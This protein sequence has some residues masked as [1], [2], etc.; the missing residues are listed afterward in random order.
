MSPEQARGHTVD[1]RSDIFALGAILY[2]ILTGRQ[3]F[4]GTTPQ[5]LAAVCN[6]DL[7]PPSSRVD[8]R[9]VP[10]E[11][12][13]VAL[14]AMA[15]RPDERYQ[16][17]NDLKE[18]VVAWRNGD[19]IAAADYTTWERVRRWAA[20]HKAVV[21]TAAAALLLVITL[22]VAFLISLDSERVKAVEQSQ[23]ADREARAA[24]E[25]RDRADSGAADAKAAREAAEH[26]ARIAREA[27]ARAERSLQVALAYMATDLLHDGDEIGAITLLSES[28]HTHARATALMVPT[29]AATYRYGIY[30]HRGAIR[31][32]AFSPDGRQLVTAGDDMVLRLWDA[33]TG[34]P[35]AEY[36]GHENRVTAVQFSANGRL[37]ISASDDNSVRIWNV[38]TADR[39]GD[40][41]PL[42]RVRSLAANSTGM[43]AFGLEDG[44]IGLW[45]PGSQQQ[46]RAAQV[47]HT[48]AVTSLVFHPSRPNVLITGSDDGTMRIV[49]VNAGMFVNN[50]R[51]GEDAAVTCVAL[52]ADGEHL[53][54]GGDD[55]T[56]MLTDGRGRENPVTRKDHTGRITSVAAAPDGRFI[57]S[58]SSDGTV[59]LRDAHTLEVVTIL[60]HHTDMVQATCFSPDGSLLATV[61][62][63]GTARVF[64][65]TPPGEDGVLE[66]ND[67]VRS[68]HF[69]PEGRALA[70][71]LRN[72]TVQL[73]DMTTRRG[74]ATGV[75]PG[76]DFTAM[77]FLSDGRMLTAQLERN[78][79][80]LSLWQP[81][82]EAPLL[83]MAAGMSRIDDLAIDPLGRYLV[84]ASARSPNALVF[85][86]R[87]EVVS[88][89]QHPD[90]VRVV[91]FS[92]DGRYLASGDQEGKVALWTTDTFKQVPWIESLPLDGQ[93]NTLT[94]SPDARQ[95][96]AA[97][98][99]GALR[100]WDLL[101][102]RELDPIHA[103]SRYIAA[104][105]YSPD[106]RWLAT[107]SD[108]H[109][110]ALW[111]AGER[112]PIARISEDGGSGT[113]RD[114]RP[115]GAV[116]ISPDGLTL[117][118][119]CDNNTI[120]LTG[121]VIPARSEDVTALTGL[122]R[123]GFGLRPLDSEQDL[124]AASV[125]AT[126]GTAAR[127]AVW[128]QPDPVA[129]G[130]WRVFWGV[131]HQ[132]DTATGTSDS[133]SLAEP[134]AKW[135]GDHPTHRM[136]AIARTLVSQ[137]MREGA[138]PLD[139]MRRI[140]G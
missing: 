10:R 61:S 39:V 50:F 107:G 45:L 99:H 116:A 95:L 83:T 70:A 66:C 80:Q 113:S 30:G 101:T 28:G 37:L 85:N 105:C 112:T 77:A 25:Q 110:V 122:L 69:S 86:H 91:E 49:D 87:L 46:P 117:A 130:F 22:V 78:G 97:D 6:G 62:V 74:M 68:L 120:R 127:Q 126:N 18:D 132:V 114:E 67:R 106:G 128:R 98:E 115:E 19:I 17:A 136:A 13:A 82:T 26:E 129:A 31:A 124:A 118:V 71:L 90:E 29:P 131:V 42:Q 134:L 9:R 34:K 38:E 57:V 135:A 2:T 24:L 59:R 48:A 20:R 51:H 27:H 36:R 138:H 104:V 23:R 52:A 58:G 73:W 72:G 81:G 75:Q 121:G 4:E 102:R 14:K 16:S 53:I 32:A 63:D 55:S 96:M 137:M 33:H 43:V 125:A 94:F 108:D 8:P 35:V 56:V 111:G 40:T 133:E 109:T 44:T 11:L 3:P 92:P 76:R 88:T 65:I 64:N 84:A 5:I 1:A 47:G 60:R 41:R 100:I 15:L 21:S 123:D 119:A 89:L 79:T 12:E 140:T 93:I 54:S 7:T 139:A 103:H